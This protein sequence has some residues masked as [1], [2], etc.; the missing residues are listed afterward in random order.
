MLAAVATAGQTAAR[1][2]AP[3]ASCP[4]PSGT[5]SGPA[6]QLSLFTRTLYYVREDHP[7]DIGPRSR[8]L[9]LGALEA[10]AVQD[11]ALRVRRNGDV[12]PRW[13]TVTVDD[14]PCTL[15]LEEVNAPWSLRRALQ[16]VIQFT[17]AYLA[18]K[19]TAESTQ[20]L[21]R[22]QFAATNGMLSALDGR[23]LL[24]DPQTYRQVRA[25]LP[26][27]SLP[28]PVE[29][30]SI[31]AATP[32]SREPIVYLR[33]RTFR[34][35]VAGEVRR[36]LA[37][38]ESQRARGVILDLRDNPGGALD[39]AVGV[40]DAFIGAGVLGST[41]S[42]RER[43]QLVAHSDGHEPSGALVVLVNRRTA[44]GS[45]L[46]AAAVKNLGRGVVLGELTAGAGSIDVF[47]DMPDAPSQLP[48]RRPAPD[49]NRDVIQNILDDVK[50][51]PVKAEPI[52]PEILG[53]P[54]GLRLLVGRLLASGGA[55][56][57]RT[58]VRPDVEAAGSTGQEPGTDNDCLVQF[59]AA[60]MA[61]AGD[62]RRSAL[63]EAA[64]GHPIPLECGRAAAP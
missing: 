25:R 37:L 20:R 53:D 30:V 34:S 64:K 57:D 3:A 23:S 17:E 39:E 15:N 10:A 45:E 40:A 26:N 48:Q 63:L 22:I 36:A 13:V 51:D 55:E 59:A 16:Q 61:R 31:P 43:K 32:A 46:V 60:L 54:F 8:D 33:V 38:P 24:L 35:G 11:G 19:P 7:Q 1:G 50:P 12:P 42:K 9:L 4:I 6:A 29:P 52:K 5:V 62:S 44:S 47:F 58:G 2:A 18:P 14:H 41:V 56:I 28:A 21:M 49:P 27:A